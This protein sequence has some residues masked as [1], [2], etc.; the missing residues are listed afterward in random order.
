MVDDRIASGK[1]GQKDMLASFLAHGLTREEA[2]AEGLFIVIA[3]SDTS[4]TAIRA[5]LLY[6]MTTP[7]VY[8]SLKAEIK[9][10]IEGG[11]I[12]SPIKDSEAR[13]MPYLQAV[14]KEGLRIHPP[15]VVL[16]NVVPPKGGELIDGIH[17]PEGTSIG[18]SYW[19]ALR[20]KD[21]YGED[22]EVFRPERW[23]EA[24]EGCLKRMEQVH[25]IIFRV[26]K[27]QCLGKPIALMELNKVFV[28]LLRRFDFTVIDPSHPWDSSSSGVFLQSNFWVRVTRDNM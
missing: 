23:L 5:T 28:E 17:V 18:I 11:L 12:S 4:A 10:A 9:S 21:V 19:A 7:L 24:E 6:L 26:G 14:I 27:W 13:R 15:V 25:E 16:G 22:A 8:N 20:N 1:P 3:G 2:Q